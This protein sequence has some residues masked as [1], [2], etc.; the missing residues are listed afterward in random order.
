MLVIRQIFTLF[1]CV[2][3][4]S[5]IK[6][7]GPSTVKTQ[8]FDYNDA[9]AD[10]RSKTLLLNIVRLRYD[11]A[12]LIVT[13]QS[14]SQNVTLSESIGG[15]AGSNWGGTGS[16]GALMPFF[17]TVTGNASG[18][19]N[20][21]YTDNP[22]LQF[23][24]QADQTF[25]NEFL[26]SLDLKSIALLL[27]SQWSIARVFRMCV[28][29]AGEAVNASSAARPTSH[30][31]PKYK[32]FDEMI[33][34][35]RR[36]QIDD[37]FVSYWGSSSGR[38]TLEL[39]MHPKI[40]LSQ[41]ERDI[42]KRAGIKIQNHIIKFTNYPGPGDT[43]VV[44]RSILGTMNYLSKGIQV[45][46]VLVDKGLAVETHY[47]NGKPFDWQKVVRG[48]MKIYSGPRKPEPEITNVA[49]PFQGFWYWV[50]ERDQNS[51][52]SLMLVQYLLGLI[53]TQQGGGNTSG[54][55]GFVINTGAS[56]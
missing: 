34:V 17:S 25:Q 41:R 6:P 49:I 44:T 47:K 22:I 11:H 27:E 20:I 45:P 15:S 26:K 50:D 16:T 42:L 4:S 5:C 30:H 52:Q 33:Y 51:K 21:S 9:F 36:I 8:L 48:M 3:L 40:H 13:L 37:G 7:I 43:F 56:R 19:G 39:H 38:E 35:L 46:K 23:V 32:L 2:L 55:P 28:Q 1:L 14:V 31:I 18:N 24:P 29:Q 54:Q 53:A 10:T 12:P